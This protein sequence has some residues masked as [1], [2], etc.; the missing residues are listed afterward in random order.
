MII[1]KL[2]I[3]GFGNMK[4][5]E[6]ILDD[7][8][9]LINGANEYG[10]TTIFSFIRAMLFG[11]KG[12]KK[13]ITADYERYIPLD[14]PHN[15]RGEMLVTLHNATYKIERNFHRDTRSCK[16]T[17]IDT[18]KSIAENQWLSMLS[19]IDFETFTS[20]CFINSE[21]ANPGNHFMQILRE[22]IIGMAETNSGDILVH[23]SIEVLNDKLKEYKNKIKNLPTYNEFDLVE[24]KN[25]IISKINDKTNE[26]ENLQKTNSNIVA[27][28][29]FLV[30]SIS[31]FTVSMIFRHNLLISLLTF[32][33]AIFSII[34]MIFLI[35]SSSNKNK[36]IDIQKTYAT[37]QIEELNSKLQTIEVELTNARNTYNEEQKYKKEIEA[38]EFAK[39]EI[40]KIA[41]EIYANN[42]NELNTRLSAI[43]SQIT[44]NTFKGVFIND[45]MNIYGVREDNTLFSLSHFSRGTL[46]QLYLSLRLVGIDLLYKEFSLPIILDDAFVHYDYKRYKNAITVLEKSSHQA[47][48]FNL[49]KSVL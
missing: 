17:D 1:K 36:N 28:I 42:T 13:E 39:S 38:I 12:Q 40:N 33:P 24:N 49:S 25:E 19:P 3:I 26:F 21:T 9:N 8:F 5:A 16:I 29:A 31:L 37:V 35:M 7:S 22:R 45:D 27:I 30:I 44:N 14:N 32:I 41:K 11:L 46:E 15:Y 43:F 18:G 2:Y 34:A 20:T 23:T 48:I 47:I 10:K 6:L 4:N